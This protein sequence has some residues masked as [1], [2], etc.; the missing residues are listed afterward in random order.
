MRILSEADAI[1]IGN[2]V[3]RYWAYNSYD[4]LTLPQILER[5]R[6]ELHANA[7]R[8]YNFERAMQG[9]ALTM[10][11]R[12]VRVNRLAHSRALTTL[13]KSSLGAQ[14]ALDN[15]AAKHDIPLK[16]LPKDK[17]RKVRVNTASPKQVSAFLYDH[18]GLPAQWK[19]NA[20]GKRVRTSDKDALAK[21]ADQFP[22][23]PGLDEIAVM[24]FFAEQHKVLD[25]GVSDDGRWHCSFNVGATETGRWSSS[26]SPMHEG[27]NLQ[28][29]MPSLRNIFEADPGYTLFYADLAQADSLGIAYL[30]QEPDYIAAHKAGNVHVSSGQILW[31]EHEWTKEW[32]KNTSLP[33]DEHHTWYDGSKRMQHGNNFAQTAK[34]LAKRMRMSQADAREAQGRYFAC[35][36]GITAYHDWVR[37]EIKRTG[38]LTTPLG[39][40]RQFLGRHWD[41]ATIREAIAH[42][43]Q[44][45]TADILDIGLW[46]VWRAFDPEPI[47]ILANGH[48]AI[49][50]QV[51]SDLA[52][53]MIPEVLRLMRVRVMVHGREMVIP[54]EAEVGKNWGAY[55]AED[56]PEGLR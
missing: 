47:Q 25:R 34:G 19:M 4:C 46:R 29:I 9:P 26:Y 45:M 32:A 56:N 41:D 51:R 55:D 16:K 50:G 18:L 2:P 10:M 48:D 38:M 52:V 30:A 21:L 13:D 1:A 33:W 36:P 20:V 15:V 43:P 24:R 17:R 28:S 35:Y 5:L 6:P 14:G 44:S 23:T 31:P 53:Q 49:L 54:V 7:T 8:V 39:R 40:D 12:G 3:L 22:N 42:T 27:G 37:T 11:L